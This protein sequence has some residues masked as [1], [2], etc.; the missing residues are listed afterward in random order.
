MPTPQYI[1]N[2]RSKIGHELLWLPGAT[3]VIQRENGDVLLVRRSDTGAWTP[4]TGIVDP[5]E[6]PALTCLREAEEEAGVTI[7]VVALAQVKVE[8]PMEFAN[9]DRCQFLDHTFYCRYLTG[10]ARVN[11]EESSE[12]RWVAPDRIETLCSERMVDRIKAALNWQNGTRF[13]IEEKH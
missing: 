13:F 6:S 11:D 2:L 8:P 4:V 12:V 1:V 10:K 7:E 5:G 3:A 9:G